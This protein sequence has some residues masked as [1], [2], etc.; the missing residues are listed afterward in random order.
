MTLSSIKPMMALIELE[1][2]LGNFSQ[3]QRE[4][5]TEESIEYI[6]YV[7]VAQYNISLGFLWD[8]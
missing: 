5:D 2:S 3:S 6:L 8:L 4:R 7:H 1:I